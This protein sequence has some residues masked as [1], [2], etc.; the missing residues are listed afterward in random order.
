MN[1]PKCNAT[2]DETALKPP[3][4]GA[5]TRAILL[6]WRVWVITILVMALSGFLASLIFP[7]SPG[8]GTVG[9]GAVTG[10]LIAL[11]MGRLRACPACSAT[12]PIETKPAT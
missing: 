1:C 7:A 2:I 4:P 6:D 3:T 8:V 5:L 9:G 12:I 11:R 10:M